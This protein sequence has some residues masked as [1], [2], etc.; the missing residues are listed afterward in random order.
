MSKE[1]HSVRFHAQGITIVRQAPTQL[2]MKLPLQATG[3]TLE[4][5][6]ASL[7]KQTAAAQRWL[8]SLGAINIL[9]GDPH[10]AST[11][12]DNPI[13]RASEMTARMLGQAKPTNQDAARTKTVYQF[14]TA[15]WDLTGKSAEERL[16]LLDRLQFEA[17]SDTP[18]TEESDP[19]PGNEMFGDPQQMQAMLAEMMK[20]KEEPRQAHFLFITRLGEE[21]IR[22]A[23]QEA[24]AQACSKAE[25]LAASA[26]LTLGRIESVGY[27]HA[28]DYISPYRHMEQQASHTILAGTG[29]QPREHESVSE[30]PL[31]AEFRLSVTVYFV[32]EAEA[33]TL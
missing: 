11:S 3:A 9:T 33:K 32:N 1:P 5:G 10:F 20:P 16:V 8:Q 2:L 31:S 30:Q 17:A 6:L 28:T 25:Q 19:L 13:K 4:L 12:S 14:L 29:Y 7:R 15:F 24:F 27:G 18:M 22:Q 23:Y 26:G 21:A